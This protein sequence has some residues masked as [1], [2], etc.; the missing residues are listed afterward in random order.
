MSEHDYACSNTNTNTGAHPP[1]ATR[2]WR[3]PQASFLRSYRIMCSFS[4]HVLMHAISF[5]SIYDTLRLQELNSSF[6][7]TLSLSTLHDPKPLLTTKRVW[8]AF[9]NAEE[10]IHRRSIWIP[11]LLPHRTRTIVLT[12]KWHD[13]GQGDCKG[14]LFVGGRANPMYPNEETLGS[15]ENGT[16]VYESPLPPQEEQSLFI[17]FSYDPS[18]AYYLW[19]RFG[20]DGQQ[21]LHVRDL[22]MYTVVSD[23]ADRWIGRNYNTLGSVGFLEN[24]DKLEYYVL[25]RLAQD[26]SASQ[27]TTTLVESFLHDNRL[28]ASETSMKALGELASAFLEYKVRALAHKQS[29]LIQPILQP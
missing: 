27:E 2:P 7:R 3:N 20:G 9:H 13:A 17:S 4:N 8:L 26:D 22:A 19:Y 23:C 11:A 18:K 25:L 1:E 12:C 24:L 16:I 29:E 6:Q 28:D 10:S 15:I 14:A 21:H 5:L